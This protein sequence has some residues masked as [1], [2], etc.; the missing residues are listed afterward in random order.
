MCSACI[1]K[2]LGAHYTHVVPSTTHASGAHSHC[3]GGPNHREGPGKM[4]YPNEDGQHTIL[5]GIWTA[6]QQASAHRAI[7]LLAC[8]LL[9]LFASIEQFFLRA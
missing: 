4:F 8:F 3:A 7:C 9:C 1:R 2:M 6:D 5:T